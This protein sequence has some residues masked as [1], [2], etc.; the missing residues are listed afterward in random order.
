MMNH[1]TI[2]STLAQTGF[3]GQ[4]P[5]NERALI[6]N[7]IFAHHQM[8]NRIFR[9]YLIVDTIEKDFTLKMA[10]EVRN[11]IKLLATKRKKSHDNED[12]CLSHE[13]VVKSV[14]NEL[15]AI[16]LYKTDMFNPTVNIISEFQSDEESIEDDIG[17][18]IN[19]LSNTEEM[20]L[21]FSNNSDLNSLIRVCDTD[22]DV[23]KITLILLQELLDCHQR[24]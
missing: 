17:K 8:V 10:L 9:D 24:M 11:C 1:C 18:G 14:I 12:Q 16:D 23:H 2:I 5:T 6:Y 4:L 22:A 19:S 21:L 13:Q 20:Y 15:G 7:E 3:F